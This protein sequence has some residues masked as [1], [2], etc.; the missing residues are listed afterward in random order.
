MDFR[1]AAAGPPVTLL[2]AGGLL[3]RSALA[4]VGAQ[5][6]SGARSTFE[7]L[8]GRG[9]PTLVADICFIN[10]LLLV[11]NLLPGLPL[12]G[13]RIARARRLVAHRATATAPRA[14][15]AAAGRGLAY[16][17]GGLGVYAVVHGATERRHLARCSSRMILG[18]AARSAEAQ[19]RGRR[20][21][22]EGLRV[23]DVMDAEPVAVP[24]G[25]E[26]DRALDE[27]FLRYGWDWFPVVDRGGRFLGLV[28][29]GAWR[30]A[31]GAAAGTQRERR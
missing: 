18:Q 23:A 29:A 19:T 1:I 2:I 14:S 20:R 11:F 28:T 15:M 10:T 3:R 21:R 16:L 22:I 6:R 27:Y 17:V 31:R 4:S 26:L 5:R 12:D 24:G 13:G 9:A 30:G 7:A 25:H 8:A